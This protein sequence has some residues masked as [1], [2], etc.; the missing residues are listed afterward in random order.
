MKTLAVG[1]SIKI[2]TS[3]GKVSGTLPD[4]RRLV[5]I[6]RNPTSG[7]GGGARQLLILIRELRSF[8]F[9]VRLFASRQRLDQ[10]LQCSDVRAQIRCIVAAG[11]DGTVG[12]VVNR[13]ADM[14]IA[15]LP[16]GTENLLARHLQIPR[17]GS[18]VAR[19]IKHGAMQSF[20]VGSV[21][22]QQFLLMLSVGV[23][24]DVVR[25][26][27]T[28]RRGNIRHSSYIRPIF[29]SFCGY[30]FFYLTTLRS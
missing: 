5:V 1:N 24:A 26:L 9:R 22:G 11:G 8:G 2:Q 16:L 28:S 18:F 19:L 30:G 14:P 4:N 21:N 10:F 13:H 29:G 23:D 17:C 7:S 20:D 15:S 27:H 3:N 25:R 12:S 6:Q